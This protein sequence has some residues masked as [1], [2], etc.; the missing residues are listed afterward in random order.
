MKK[1]NYQCLSDTDWYALL[2]ILGSKLFKD[3]LPS[4]LSKKYIQI[5]IMYIL[6]MGLDLLLL[7]FIS[8]L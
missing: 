4:L 8:F 1:L 3:K 7:V 2:F 6:F 5:Y